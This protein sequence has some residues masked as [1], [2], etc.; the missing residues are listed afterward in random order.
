MDNHLSSGVRTLPIT[1]SASQ[2]GNY[3]EEGLGK[4]YEKIT[5]AQ[6]IKMAEVMAIAHLFIR[7]LLGSTD[8]EILD[9]AE[10][11]YW[12]EYTLAP[13]ELPCW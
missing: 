5:H 6:Q 12:G 11:V 4:T 9:I 10:Q 7:T 1:A 2:Y 13:S 3:V 8:Q